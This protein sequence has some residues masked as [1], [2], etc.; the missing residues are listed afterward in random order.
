MYVCICH[1]VTDRQIREA[2]R[3]GASSIDAL[4]RQ[5]RVASR[6]GRCETC[7]VEVLASC[8]ERPSASASL[9]QA[10]C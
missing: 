4:R 9:A 7:A 10:A 3:D 8:L 2:A 1:S 5:L 6:C